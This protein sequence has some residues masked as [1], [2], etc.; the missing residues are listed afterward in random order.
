MN[1]DLPRPPHARRYAPPRLRRDE[2]IAQTAIAQHGRRIALPGPD[3][4]VASLSP[5]PPSSV[6]APSGKQPLLSMAW[7]GGRFDLF[8]DPGTVD[9]IVL[10]QFGA[11]AATHASPTLR[12]VAFEYWLHDLLERHGLS[13]RGAPQFHQPAPTSL[14]F[15]YR[16]RIHHAARTHPT[17]AAG[18][19]HCNAT[20]H[21]LLA[22]LL[23]RR[24]VKTT[25]A[26][27]D[28]LPLPQRLSVGCCRVASG[29]LRTLRPHD[30]LVVQDQ[31]WRNGELQVR[32]SPT[33]A[34]CARVEKSTL[35]VTRGLYSIMNPS[36]DDF[37]ADLPEH[38]HAD[39]SD[40]DNA[41]D[42]H[43]YPAAATAEA[44][45][46]AMPEH[47][48][49]Q[50]FAPA[51]DMPDAVADAL[52]Q[53]PVTLHFDLGRC[54]MTLAQLR[55]LAPGSVLELGRAPG[56]AV[57]IRTDGLLVGHGE[58]VEVDGLLGVAI[59][60]LRWPGEER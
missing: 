5:V 49:P 30:V 27:A 45:G 58:L 36:T 11:S 41:A 24:P 17:E 20:G 2:A 59:T 13:V 48:T 6:R 31:H 52:D 43:R 22:S 56:R 53:V 46:D 37:P 1:N 51:A 19:L 29:T 38:R 7:S 54:D 4:R 12:A 15:R 28:A 60:S 34:W 9:A 23:G 47:T 3:E 55:T 32:A 42:G 10:G 39:V 14:P 26:F 8:G 44:D 57:A 33:L 21:F 40:S 16:W 50:T 25:I 35:I 18:E